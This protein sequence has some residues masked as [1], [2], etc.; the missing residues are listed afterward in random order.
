MPDDVSTFIAM[1]EQ[2][3]G[4]DNNELPN[5][6]HK[7]SSNSDKPPGIMMD[8]ELDGDKITFVS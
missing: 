7:G 1:Q 6:E 5:N 2:N 4:V 8:I 3:A